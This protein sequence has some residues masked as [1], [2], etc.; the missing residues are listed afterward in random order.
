MPWGRITRW[1]VDEECGYI[2]P[3]E[4]E[5]GCFSSLGDGGVFFFRSWS[6]IGQEVPS[7][8][9]AV[10]YT[11]HWELK[12]DGSLVWIVSSVRVLWEHA[13]PAADSLPLGALEDFS[14]D[15]GEI[16]LFV[17]SD[18][19][20]IEFPHSVEGTTVVATEEWD[21]NDDDGTIVEDSDGDDGDEEEI[22]LRSQI[23]RPWQFWPGLD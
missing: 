16:D 18:D 5:D 23:S 8:G 20:T 17:T 1:M 19:G 15:D 12:H 4:D 9:R 14:S 7:E 6:L 13:V 2:A 3:E 22:P 21:D 11:G 10:R